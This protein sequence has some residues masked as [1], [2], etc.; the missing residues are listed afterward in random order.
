MI[1]T[2]TVA[3]ATQASMTVTRGAGHGGRP[4][5]SSVQFESILSDHFSN[6]VVQK[7]KKR[8]VVE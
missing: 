1:A 3:R 7:P 6:F 8:Q 2:M 4:P 5:L